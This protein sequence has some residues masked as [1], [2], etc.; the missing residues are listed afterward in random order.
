[1]GRDPK[2]WENP[3]EFRPERFMSEEN[4]KFDMR[5][6]NFQLMP[7]GSGRRACPGYSLALQVVPTNLAAMIQCFEWKVDGN[8]KVNM[9]EKPAVTL[10]REHPLICVPVP[11]FNSIPSGE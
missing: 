2:L 8:E 5:G 9:E 11:R 1:M 7:F 4:N 3:L 10:P 6:Q